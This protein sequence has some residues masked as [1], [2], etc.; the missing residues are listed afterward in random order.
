MKDMFKSVY[1]RVFIM[2]CSKNTGFCFPYLNSRQAH[3]NLAVY[4]RLKG[5]GKVLRFDSSL[6]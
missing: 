6:F 2:L 3:V 4:C 5:E 1:R